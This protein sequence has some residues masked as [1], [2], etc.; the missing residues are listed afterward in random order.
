MS[1]LKQSF[2]ENSDDLLRVGATSELE[3]ID[4]SNLDKMPNTEIVKKIN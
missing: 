2:D 3:E 1:L 4:D